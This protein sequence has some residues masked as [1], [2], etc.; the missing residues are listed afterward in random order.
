MKEIIIGTRGSELALYQ[1]RMVAGELRDSGYEGKIVEKIIQT[2]GDKHKD[3]K[4][5]EF[6][7]GDKPLTDKGVFTKELEE[8]LIRKEVDIAVHSLKDLPSDLGEDFEIGAIMK[9]AATNDVLISRFDSQ[10]FR[11]LKK[12]TVISTGS[13]RRSRVIQWKRP[14][15]KVIDIRGNVPT[16]LKKLMS[17]EFG[18]ATILA[19]AGLQRLGLYDDKNKLLKF[20]GQMIGTYELS[21]EEFIPCGGQGAIAIEALSDSPVLEFTQKIN[22]Q[23]T[24]ECIKIEREFL[25]LLGAGCDTPVGV[26]AFLSS[27]GDEM[28][29][30]AILFD[31]SN[32]SSDPKIAHCTVARGN[33][34]GVAK[35]L[36]KQMQINI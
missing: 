5:S 12:E 21:V 6:S 11:D 19:Q 20:D 25:K 2:S 10:S 3:I 4:L 31:E 29:V 18:D 32:L 36:L 8:S 30:R 9:R 15:I 34:Q 23:E 35:N 16:R 28:S 17:G 27:S 24:H 1:A 13:V 22:H 7:K 14:D 33:A 26:N